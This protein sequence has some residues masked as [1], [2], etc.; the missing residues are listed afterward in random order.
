MM[1]RNILGYCCLLFMMGWAGCSEEGIGNYQADSY[2]YFTKAGNDSTTFSFAYDSSLKEGDVSLKM[3]LI[4]R[5]ENRD[6]PFAV[7]LVEE[8]STAREGRDFSINPQSLVVKANDS[9]AYMVVHVKKDAS[10]EGR[11]VKAVFEVVASDEFLPGIGK[12][13]KANVI[14]TDKLVRPEWWNTWH[15]SS[16]LGTYS[17][18]KFRLFIE[19]TGRHDLTL[20]ED[21]GTMEYS[22]MRGYVVMF[23]YWLYEHPQKEDDGSDMT[24]PVIG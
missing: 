11:S 20:V 10:L 21:G 12:N 8:E 3:N 19:V 16:G 18:K 9:I 13:R 22:D 24:V 7:R 15:E 5:L 1:K 4:S 17:D 14:I 6:R 23:K 2:I